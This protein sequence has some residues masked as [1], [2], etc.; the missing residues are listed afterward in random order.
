MYPS[1]RPHHCFAPHLRLLIPCAAVKVSWYFSS[2]LSNGS[3]NRTDNGSRLSISEAVGRNKT[4]IFASSIN[5]PRLAFDTGQ[6]E[7][8][9]ARNFHVWQCKQ[10]RWYRLFF[11]YGPFHRHGRLVSKDNQ[12]GR[13]RRSSSPRLHRR[14]PQYSA[15]RNRYIY[16]VCMRM[17]FS[18]DCRDVSSIQRN[19][20]LI[21]WVRLYEVV[22]A[23]KT[24]VTNCAF[25][26]HL[27]V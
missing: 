18:D 10:M 27:F 20:K 24:V 11:W 17:W 12:R 23:G 26:L 25:E 16:F 19:K 4:S 1:K 3:S 15:M 7:H 14:Y 5:T 9:T 8:S 13:L 22:T 21:S 2:D 6:V